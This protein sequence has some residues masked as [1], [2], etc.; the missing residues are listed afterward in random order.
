MQLYPKLEDV[1]EKL[2]VSSWTSLRS[3]VDLRFLHSEEAQQ[4]GV[5]VD[6]RGQ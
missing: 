6:M 2:S 5:D 3:A 1:L 4:C